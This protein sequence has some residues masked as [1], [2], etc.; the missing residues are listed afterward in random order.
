[1]RL[2]AACGADGSGAGIEGDRGVDGRHWS[3]AAGRRRRYHPR[4]ADSA[5]EW[6]SHRRSDRMPAD[7]A[8]ARIA[9]LYAA[10]DRVP[11]LR[12]D[13]EYVLSGH[14]GSDSDL[15]AHADA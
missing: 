13:D 9:E 11:R 1:M 3:A 6:R 4:V 14:G 10:S 8:G 2:R 5:A 15:S 7:F 12:A